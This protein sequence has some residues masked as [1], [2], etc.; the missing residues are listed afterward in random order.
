MDAIKKHLAQF[1]DPVGAVWIRSKG[2]QA[3]LIDFLKSKNVP[4]DPREVDNLFRKNVVLSI[5]VTSLRE[6]HIALE[7]KKKREME[8]ECYVK[9]GKK[10]KCPKCRMPDFFLQISELYTGASPLPYWKSKT[11]QGYLETQQTDRTSD[12]V[13][14]GIRNF[15]K[16]TGI[17]VR[18]DKEQTTLDSSKPPFSLGSVNEVQSLGSKE[19]NE[20]KEP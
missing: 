9:D 17:E 2:F 13:R 7:N 19:V 3:R 12:N 15:H 16:K 5:K 1:P 14:G 4:F 6:K 8:C 11:T 18:D 20:I 10:R